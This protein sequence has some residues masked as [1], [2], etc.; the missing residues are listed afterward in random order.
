[1]R[2]VLATS[3]PGKIKEIGEILSRLGLD[4]TT[5]EELGVCIDIEETGSTFYE[6]ALI[7]AKAICDLTKM[8]AI[9]DDSGLC[10]DFLDGGPGLYTSSYG[11]DD[12]DDNGR[13]MFLLEKLKNVEQRSAKF[14]CNIVCAFP[15]GSLISAQ[16]VCYG[17]ITALPRGTGGFGFDP[18]FQA[19]GKTKTMAEL[20]AEE[21]NRISHRGKALKEFA[22]LLERTY[23]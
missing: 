6:N 5:R 23:Y 9:A 22:E 20:P 2:F 14:V 17:E 10:V 21:K 12:L 16:G 19:E 8:P 15:D 18:V 4:V 13:C 7:K 3:N 1:M 11:S